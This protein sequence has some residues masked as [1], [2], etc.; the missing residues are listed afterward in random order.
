MSHLLTLPASSRKLTLSKRPRTDTDPDLL[1]DY[2][3]ALI[4]NNALITKEVLNNELNELLD[5]G[6]SARHLHDCANPSPDRSGRPRR[7]TAGRPSRWHLSTR[8]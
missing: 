2:I 5:D 4:N 1:S 7:H 3:I 8:L 6:E